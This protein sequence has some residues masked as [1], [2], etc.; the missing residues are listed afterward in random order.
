M[1]FQ[2][3][4]T[5]MRLGERTRKAGQEFTGKPAFGKIAVL[6]CA[7]NRGNSPSKVF[8]SDGGRT[9]FAR[10]LATDCELIGH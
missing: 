8:E 10:S 4:A 6:G 5:A 1:G 3:G 7:I 2:R 9:A